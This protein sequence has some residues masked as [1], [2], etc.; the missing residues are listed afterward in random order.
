MSRASF[1]TTS[2]NYSTTAMAIPTGRDIYDTMERGDAREFAA[3]SPP[4]AQVVNPTTTTF[5]NKSPPGKFWRGQ[6]HIDTRSSSNDMTVH[7]R[8][9]NMMTADSPGYGYYEY[10]FPKEISLPQ[11]INQTLNYVVMQLLTTFLLTLLAYMHKDAVNNYLVENPGILWVP[12]ITSFITLIPMYCT[13]SDGLKKCLFV[14][15]TLSIS[16]VVAVST[17]QYAPNVILNACATLFLIV[18]GVNMYAKYTAMRGEDFS[19]MGPALFGSLMIIIIMSVINI[20]VKTTFLRLMIAMA[21]V[22]L[23]TM[24][25]MYDLN[26]LYSGAKQE[27]SIITDPLLAAINIYLDIINIFH[28]LLQILNGGNSNGD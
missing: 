27:D 25:L 28:N 6:K 15:F 4:I 13:K 23:F 16:S 2:D 24:L 8:P 7:E 20:F 10:Q 21:S 1:Q 19:Y 5:M 18:V 12:I 9:A 14:L 26:R 3:C 11:F 17:I 22:I